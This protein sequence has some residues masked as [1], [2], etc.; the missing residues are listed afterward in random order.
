ME[1]SENY[2]LY[3]LRGVVIH[4]GSSES[5]HYYS[6]IRDEEK[7]IEFNDILVREAEVE[8]VMSEAYGGE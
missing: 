2:F 4:S 7:W 5:G 1:L 6:Y 3:K 8:N